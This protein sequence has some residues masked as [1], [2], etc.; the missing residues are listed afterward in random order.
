M[1]E[2]FQAQPEELQNDNVGTETEKDDLNFMIDNPDMYNEGM[3]SLKDGRESASKSGD[4]ERDWSM[5]P[6]KVEDDRLKARM[7]SFKQL[8]EFN[9]LV[10]N[11][12]YLKKR[13]KVNEGHISKL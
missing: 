7:V 10:L 9:N 3:T 11:R 13:T 2:M 8:Y 1:K 4:Y 6:N 5:I 12:S